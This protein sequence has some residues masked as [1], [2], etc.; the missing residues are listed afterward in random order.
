[1]TCLGIQNASHIISMTAGAL[2]SIDASHSTSAII[3]ITFLVWQVFDVEFIIIII[4]L[5]ILIGVAIVL[6]F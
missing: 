6:F 3:K 1:M 2:W 4:L 5:F